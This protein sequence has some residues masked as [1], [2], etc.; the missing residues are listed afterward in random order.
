M[1]A[2]YSEV[3]KKNL[4]RCTSTFSALNYCG[5]TFF[6]SLSF[7]TK[8]C[9]Q[10][11]P[12]IFG[13]FAIFYSN[14]AKIVAPSSNENENYVVHLKEPSILKKTLKTASNYAP[15]DSTVLRT[16]SLTKRNKLETKASPRK[17]CNTGRILSR[18][19]TAIREWS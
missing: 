4:Y 12:P 2:I 10:T 6:K 7:Y 9:A 11:F 14:F 5:G 13:V 17:R 18:A 8:W 3:R 15:L 19:Y 16:R 1:S